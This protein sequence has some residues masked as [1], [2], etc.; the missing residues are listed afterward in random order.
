VPVVLKYGSLELLEPSGFVQVRTGIAL[1]SRFLF[2][3]PSFLPLCNLGAL[4]INYLHGS[5]HILKPTHQP[6]AQ[7]HVGES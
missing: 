1:T 6:S 7:C 5:A 3:I 4:F 2:I